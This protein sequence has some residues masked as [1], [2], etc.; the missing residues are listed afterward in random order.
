MPNFSLALP[1]TPPDPVLI[2]RMHAVKRI[3]LAAAAII[4][5]LNLCVWLVPGLACSIPAGRHLM[6]IDSA[7]ATLMCAAGLWL[8]EREN[9]HWLHWIGLA[10]SALVALFAVVMLVRNW[11]GVSIGFAVLLPLYCGV[12]VKIMSE[13]TAVRFAFIGLAAVFIRARRPFAHRVADVLVFFLGL[14]VLISA[15]EY[16][17][18]YFPAF[19]LAATRTLSFATVVCLV[20]LALAA[21]LCRVEDGVFSIFVGQG[22]GAR[23]AR[24]LW[25]I[26][27][28]MPFLREAGRAHLM[29][30][31]LFPAHY[32]TAILTS[33]A[34]AVSIA[35]LLIL[36]WYI[37][38]MEAEIRD[39]TLR[40]ELTG[41][42]N[43]RGFSL[44]S[45]QA[46]RLSQRS[47]LPFSVL[48]IDFDN[49]KQVNDALGHDAGSSY[50]IETGKIIKA[51][52][53]ETDVMGR[54]GGDEFAVAGHFS[55]AAISIAVQRLEAACAAKNAEAATRF[56]LSLSIGYA[57]AV[58]G[59][60]ETLKDLL[61]A[62]D[63]AM[64][65]EKRRRKV[66]AG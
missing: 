11:F 43:S 7:F 61:T 42:Y 19:G 6:K 46:L 62:A 45:G 48:Y 32:A 15:S 29:R 24:V 40:D 21:I 10:L 8:P 47:Q 3:C 60:H 65:A 25:P 27:L 1:S 63:K 41:L 38:G 58:E 64:Y 28:V 4:A 5:F 66:S 16:I 59:A 55:Q 57:T 54:I 9:K 56:P 52:F 51:T 34:T 22:I 26:L 53:R 20:L 18:G 50:L 17:F 13:Q 49:L 14:L 2:A 30:A 35:L 36:S 37:N 12:P 31:H 33:I 23:F 39:L 44:L